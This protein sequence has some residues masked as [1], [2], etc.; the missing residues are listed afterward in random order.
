V[1]HSRAGAKTCVSSLDKVDL[2]PIGIY[3]AKLGRLRE[4]GWIEGRTIKIEYR[5]AEGRGERYRFEINEIADI[6][7]LIADLRQRRERILNRI[8]MRTN[9]WVAHHQERKWRCASGS[10]LTL[11]PRRPRFDWVLPYVGQ[12]GYHFHLARSR[13]R[14]WRRG[15]IYGNVQD[16]FCP[17]RMS[18]N[19]NLP[20]RLF[21]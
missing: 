7:R 3:P 4:L 20:M 9:V 19:T 6:D 14:R 5:W 13:R 11:P 21:S 8:H 16:E 15:H 17:A 10:G 12:K 1:V 2:P 18:L